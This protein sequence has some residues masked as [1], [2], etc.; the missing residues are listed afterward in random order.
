MEIR[1]LRRRLRDPGPR[2]TTRRRSPARA[3]SSRVG[4]DGTALVT[5][6]DADHAHRRGTGLPRLAHP[7]PPPQG[8]HPAVRLYLP[9]EEGARLDHGQGQSDLPAGREPGPGHR[10]APAQ[11]GAA[12][13]DH[14]LPARRVVQDVRL[15]ARLHLA[16]GHA[17]ATSQT[18]PRNLEATAPPLL[19]RPLVA[20]RERSHAVQPDQR[21]HDPLPISGTRIPSPWPTAA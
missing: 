16:A 2:R 4:P 3:G 1:P 10:V 21:G 14:L 15:P 8:R 5:G 11:P 12:R 20:Q 18:P 13:L 6:Q 7:T 19:R 17:S 9:V